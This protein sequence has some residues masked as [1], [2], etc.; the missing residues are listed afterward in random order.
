MPYEVFWRVGKVRHLSMLPLRVPQEEIVMLVKRHNV[1]YDKCQLGLH[2]QGKFPR[3]IRLVLFL[4]GRWI[5]PA[6]RPSAALWV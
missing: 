4:V 2:G 5:E 1:Q 6:N 3:R